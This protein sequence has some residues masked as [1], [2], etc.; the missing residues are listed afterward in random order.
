MWD[1]SKVLVDVLSKVVNVCVTYQS[2]GHWL[3]IDA[4]FLAITIS[5]K[6][7]EKKKKFL[8]R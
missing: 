5:C 7:K 4:L 2:K 6:L 3:L 8:F 1:I